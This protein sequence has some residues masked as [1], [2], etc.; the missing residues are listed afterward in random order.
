MV[1]YARDSKMN[2]AL[3][4]IDIQ[5][6]QFVGLDEQTRLATAQAMDN[7][8]RLL[9][10]FRKAGRAVFHVQ[11]HSEYEG[12]ALFLAGTPGARLLDSV[13][14]LAGEP[15][16]IKHFASGFYR[17][18]LHEQ[19]QK[20][21]IDTM[22]VCGMATNFCVESTVRA[23]HELEYTLYVVH[24][25]CAAAPV[26]WEGHTFDALSVHQAFMATLNMGAFASMQAT[27][28]CILGC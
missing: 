10:A 19:L 12:A 3:L 27:D 17:T 25:A 11:H 23:A 7:A 8:A 28:E 9:Q 24:D 21:H 4:L 5:H 2:S 6:D 13:T 22:Y 1:S 18:N 26:Q 20:A 16:I 15:V 14:P